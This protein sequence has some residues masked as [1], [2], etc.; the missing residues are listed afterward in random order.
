MKNKNI[1]GLALVAGRPK[2]GLKEK[3]IRTKL[4]KPAQL[5]VQN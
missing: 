1:G 3:I 4:R 5:N 2:G